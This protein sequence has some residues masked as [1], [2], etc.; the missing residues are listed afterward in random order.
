VPTWLKY[1]IFF[2]IGWLFGAGIITVQ[3][4]A[5]ALQGVLT[6]FIPAH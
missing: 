5:N 6:A 4:V 2:V 3:D 1:V